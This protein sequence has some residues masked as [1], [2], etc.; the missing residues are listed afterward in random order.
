[1]TSTSASRSTRRAGADG[2]GGSPRGRRR[3][4]VVAIAAPGLAVAAL[5]AALAPAATS[6]A[7]AHLAAKPLLEAISVPTYGTVL[8]YSNGRSL[9]VLTSERGG[10]ITCKGACLKYWPPVL[11]GSGVKTIA[12]GPG[13]KG[14]I[15]FVAR[16]ATTKQV[17]FDGYPVYL[18]VGD[19]GAHQTHGEGVVFRG[20]TWVLV[21]CAAKTRAA[22][23]IM[24]MKAATST[25]AASSGY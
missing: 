7:G 1:M 24:P 17:T 19:K 11:V 12:V 8:G 2:S 15:G 20:G 4:R 6:A 14:T 25:T 5:G 13:V 3:A 18:F 9:Y 10:K 22:S 23:L 16:S 21:R